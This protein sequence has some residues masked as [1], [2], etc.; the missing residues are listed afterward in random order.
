MPNTINFLVKY[1][2]KSYNEMWLEFKDCKKYS[3]G[4]GDKGAEGYTKL[5]GEIQLRS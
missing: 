4:K 3:S 5:E 2:V 1:E